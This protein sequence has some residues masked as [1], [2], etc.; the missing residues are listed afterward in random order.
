M[1]DKELFDKIHQHLDTEAD[2]IDTKTANKLY[3]SRRKALAHYH[4]QIEM[5]NNGGALSLSFKIDWKQTSI[6]ILALF[7]IVLSYIHYQKQDLIVPISREDYEIL[8]NS[9]T[10]EFYADLE[11]YLWL[12]DAS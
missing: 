7:T 2:G 6:A 5:N 11:F 8:S 3:Q 12:A 10:P 4:Q 1:N 9:E